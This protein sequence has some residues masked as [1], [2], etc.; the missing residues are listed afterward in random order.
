MTDDQ[1]VLNQLP[2]EAINTIIIFILIKLETGSVIDSPNLAQTAFKVLS[3]FTESDLGLYQLKINLKSSGK[4]VLTCFLDK[5]MS[6]FMIRKDNLSPFCSILKSFMNFFTQL[7]LSCQETGFGLRSSEVR[8]L[9]KSSDPSSGPD[10]LDTLIRSCQVS[11]DLQVQETVTELKS[12]MELLQ[13]PSSGVIAIQSEPKVSKSETLAVLFANRSLEKRVDSLLLPSEESGEM[14][15]VDL[16]TL[17]RCV[18][19]IEFNLSQSLK[20]QIL[21]LDPGKKTSKTESEKK[22]TTQQQQ[23]LIPAKTIATPS[24]GRGRATG[25]RYDPFRTRLPNTSRPPSTHVDDFVAMEKDT[26]GQL[27]NRRIKD[28]QG[29][30]TSSAPSPLYP[31]TSLSVDTRTTIQKGAS[32]THNRTSPYLSPRAGSSHWT[33]SPSTSQTPDLMKRGQ[34]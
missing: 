26:S 20:E 29:H 34:R 12:F 31:S 28:F 10:S 33:K 21:V 5:L 24:R 19:G 23:L 30:R 7:I 32:F 11:S 1:Q 4:K 3:K 16:I 25:I 9:L 18:S 13:K 22:A 6:L 17:G 2:K 14:V 8:D 27:K 15:E